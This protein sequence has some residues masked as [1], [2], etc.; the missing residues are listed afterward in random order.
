MDNISPSIFIAILGLSVIII[1]M[2]Y[3]AFPRI[4]E[5]NAFFHLHGHYYVLFSTIIIY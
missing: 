4:S 5:A 1:M 3:S 2:V